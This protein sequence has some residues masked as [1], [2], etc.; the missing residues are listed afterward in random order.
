MGVVLGVLYLFYLVAAIPLMALVACAV[1]SV[2]IPA[3]YLTALARVLVIRPAW[4][5]EPGRWPRVAEDADPAVLQ[6]FYGPALADAQHAAAV[7]FRAGREFWQSG[8]RRIVSSFSGDAP[9]MTSPLGVGGAAGMAVGT[10]AGTLAA[11]GFALVYLLVVSV[12]AAGARAAGIALLG[13]DSAILRIKNIRMV[14][15]QCS[16]RVPYPGYFCP[17]R[18]CEHRHRDVRPGRFGIV[19]RR[20]RC[21]TPMSTLL[22]FG[23]WRTAAFC[24]R[25][26]E[27]LEHRPG[28][29]RE[30]VLPFIGATGAGKTRLLFSIVT[31]LRAWDEAG[32]LSAEFAD[33]ITARELAVAEHILR[34]GSNTS[35]TSMRLPRAYLIRVKAGPGRIRRKTRRGQILQLFDAA[36]E[37]FYQAGRTQELAYL[38][39]AQTFILVIDP[40]SVDAF[41]ARLL[42]EQQAGL[43]P[44]RST[45]PS[46]DL[47]YQ[48]THQQIEAMGVRLRGT[49][50]AVVFS[51]ADL[52][53]PPEGDIASWARDELGLGNLMRSAQ[54]NFREIRFFFTAAVMCDNGQIHESVPALMRWILAGHGVSLPGDGP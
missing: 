40:L 29:G 15:P 31:Q 38:D 30:I 2:G 7:G 43:A 37:R 19:R 5:P 45:A 50:L 33:S 8:A 27:R 53:D 17:G 46:P 14:C 52:I 54:L 11:A 42:P 13:V 23:S 18:R 48:G 51:R 39:K 32:Q 21:G 6:Y 44:V 24:P 10:A 12:S 35:L 22:L 34:T 36:G 1:Y 4:L 9:L 41:W 25:C 26:Q 16:H 3:K 47:A 49:R 28:E 20:C